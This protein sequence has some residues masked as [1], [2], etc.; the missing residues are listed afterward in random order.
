MNFE[1]VI[2]HLSNNVPDPIEKTYMGEDGLI[3]CA[4][5]HGKLQTMVRIFRGTDKERERKVSCV[6]QCTIKHLEELKRQ[7]EQREQK[8]K[9][10]ELRRTGFPDGQLKQWTFENDDNSHPK[11]STI[12]KK[13]VEN[14]QQLKKD[15][16]GLIFYGGVGTGKTFVAACI[17]NALINKGIPAMVTN[18]NY[19]SNKLQESFEGKQAYLN[20]LNLLDLLVIDDFGA[21]RKTEYMQE[22]IFN[23]IDARYRAGLPMVITTN[24]TL[25]QIKNPATIEERRVMDR[26][27]EKCFPIEVKGGSHR[28]KNVREQYGDMKDLLGLN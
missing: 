25:D 5:C 1:K 28:R 9:I 19:I 13:Y 17:A 23:V 8:K 3:R 4:K 11:V 20:R 27:L 14:F 7:Q 22:V 6:C 2:D 26:V 12:A 16:K 18:F 24:L 15:G 10:E 21:E